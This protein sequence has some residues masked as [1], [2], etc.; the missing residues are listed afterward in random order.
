MTH[1]LSPARRLTRLKRILLGLLALMLVIGAVL[2][3]KSE[4]IILGA[5]AYIFGYPLVIM[6]VT[7]AN[8]ALALAPEN[9][10]L[11]ARHFPDAGFTDVVRPNVDT[12]YT[13]GFIDMAKGHGRLDQCFCR[14]WQAYHRYGR[15]A[16]SAGWA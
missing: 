11:K 3:K 13:T 8:A 1:A 14:A 9:T 15:W 10:L 16:L 4:Q 5:E 2:Y 12:L 6:D 7:R